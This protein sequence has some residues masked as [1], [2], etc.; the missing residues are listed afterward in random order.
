M[1]SGI[2]ERLNVFLKYKNLLLNLVSRDIKVRYRRSVLGLL[3]TVLN[4]LLMMIVITIVFSTLFNQNIP[5]FPIYYLSGSLI[6][7][8]NSETTSNALYSIIGN[9]SLMK[10]VYIPKYLFPLAKVVSGLVNLGFSLIAMFAVMIVLNVEFQPTL[11]LLPI[12][13]FFTFLFSTGLG[14]ILAAATVFFRDIAHFYGVFVLAWTYFT[15]IFY[16]ET[17]LPPTVMSIMKFNPMYHFVSYSRQL[18]LF[19]TFPGLRETFICFIIGASFF[20]V[21]LYVFYKKQD[22]F[23]LYI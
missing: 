2:Q 11:L 19:G 13:V 7:S 1:L 15:P 14:M 4:P 23:V 9:S 22:R 5:N 21:G 20:V 12:P 8:F 17:I 10:K 16:P 18:V 6:F 3:W